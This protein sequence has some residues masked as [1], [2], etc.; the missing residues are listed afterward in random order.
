MPECHGGSDIKHAFL[1]RLD[2]LLLSRCFDTVVAVSDDIR[3]EFI[4]AYGFPEKKVVAIRNG[5]S[6]PEVGHSLKRP[7]FVIGSSGRL[8]PVKDYPLMMA[9]A[10]IARDMGMNARFE[11]AGDG[12]EKDKLLDRIN[13]YGLGEFF[14]LRGFLNDIFSFYQGLDLYIN[15]SVHEG[16][17]LSILEAMAHGLPII[18]P[19]VGGLPEIITDGV[20]GFLIS[21][22]RPEDFAEKC[23]VL[24]EDVDLRQKMGAAGRLKIIRDFSLEKMASD[25]FN[26]YRQTIASE[27]AH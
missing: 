21:G 17:P 8:F 27:K 23:R 2:R 16:I 10:G 4:N 11:L 12:I 19:R 13:Q 25:Y 5:I 18:A 6:I 3:R 22:R 9:V 14:L 24:F 26:L 15:T 7:D 20:E 1:T